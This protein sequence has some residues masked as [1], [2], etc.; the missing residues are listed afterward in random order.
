MTRQRIRVTL[1]TLICLSVLGAALY[2]RT[3]AATVCVNVASVQLSR[4]IVGG[5]GT[6]T[7]RSAEDWYSRALAIHPHDQRAQRSLVR[8]ALE[9]GESVESLG[10]TRTDIVQGSDLLTLFHLGMLDWSQG[11]QERAIALWRRVPISSLYFCKRGTL[12][13][14]AGETEVALA[15]Y[16][17]SLAIDPEPALAKRSMYADLCSHY[18]QLGHPD[19]A[20]HWCE[21]VVQVDPAAGN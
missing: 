8:I 14:R 11:E 21:M 4:A 12:A 1:I 18:R 7:L 16:Q 3:L 19:E 10:I 9:R 5:A 13:F 6:D 2:W 17:T 15:D 20:L